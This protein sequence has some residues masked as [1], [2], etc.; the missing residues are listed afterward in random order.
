MLDYRS[1]RIE[2]PA[3]DTSST[4][5]ARHLMHLRRQ[6]TKQTALRFL[7]KFLRENIDAAVNTFLA[8]MDLWS[9]YKFP[10][11]VLR[12][13]AKRTSQ[14]PGAAAEP[15]KGFHGTTPDKVTTTISSAGAAMKS[16]DRFGA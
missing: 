16:S 6:S 1:N 13:V 14:N 4:W 9:S 8:N 5:N 7:G 3:A 12:L 15:H 2:A 10:H 11:F